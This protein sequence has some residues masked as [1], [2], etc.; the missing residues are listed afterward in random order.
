MYE[1]LYGEPFPPGIQTAENLHRHGV[2]DGVVPLELLRTTLDRALKVV[3]DVP[4][5]PPAAPAAEP[6]PDVPAWDRWR[7]PAGPTGPA[8]GT[9]C[10]TGRRSASCLSGTER[11]EA[12]AT[13]VLALARF[14]GQ[15]A[16]VVGQQR[17]TGTLVGP[18]ALREARR[19]MA[20]AAGLRLPLV[21]V[22]DTVGPHCR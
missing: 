21:L 14:G 3:S 19:G 1:H 18:A 11:G 17:V 2:I 16:V 15:P 20:L 5:P 13:T 8:S 6:V 22:I 7:R 9:C 4:G 12:A 10:G